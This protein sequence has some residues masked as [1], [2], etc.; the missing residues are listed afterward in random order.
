[1]RSVF[2]AAVA[3]GAAAAAGLTTTSVRARD[4]PFCI[5]GADYSKPLGDC[6]FD[7]Y[8]QCQASASGRL[9]YCD[10]NYFFHNSRDA[11]A[12]HP[13]KRRRPQ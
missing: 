3:V 8:Q 9:D 5:K 4:Y 6:I 12:A 13:K 11:S 1:M 10:R 7:T 2:L